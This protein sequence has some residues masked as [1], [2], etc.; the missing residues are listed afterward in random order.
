MKLR[1]FLLSNLIIVAIIA[2]FL[3]FG[4]LYLFQHRMPVTQNAFVVA[5]IRPVSAYVPGHITNIPVINNTKVKKGDILFTVSR[6]PYRLKMESLKYSEIALNYKLKALSHKIKSCQAAVKENQF[7]LANAKYLADQ[8]KDMYMKDA[9]SQKYY[10]ER[11]KAMEQQQA[12]LD[13]VKEELEST[14]MEYAQTQAQISSVKNQFDYAKVEYD[15]TEVK[16][17]T[18]GIVT[19]M[20]VSPG[21]YVKPGEALFALIDDN[22]WW[23]QANFKET[24]LAHIKPGQKAKIWLWQYPGKTFHGKVEATGWGVDRK[25]TDP[26]SGMQTVQKENEWFL[27]P[28]RFPVQIRIIDPDPAYPLHPGGSAYVQVETPADTTRQILWQIYNWW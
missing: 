12:V 11:T 7:I 23:V 19:N 27:L 6:E 24:E 18:D 10:E 25:I 15:L 4:G 1:K 21:A 13:G 5:N 20:Y 16:A 28:Q 2:F 3:F 26:S 17:L 8:A 22:T 9:T 14:R